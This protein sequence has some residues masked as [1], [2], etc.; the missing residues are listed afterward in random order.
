M[1]KLVLEKLNNSEMIQKFDETIDEIVVSNSVGDAKELYAALEGLFSRNPDFKTADPNIFNK[2]YE[3]FVAVRF[4][5]LPGM[6]SE[7]IVRLIKKNFS[8]VLNHPEY[9]LESKIRYKI[10]T[11][12]DLSERDAFKAKIKTVLLENGARLGRIKINV[13]GVEKDPTIANW[14]KDYYM[15]VGIE[16]ADAFKLNQHFTLSK[17]IKLLTPAEQIKLKNLFK[18]FELM[19]ISS[20]KFPQYDE[21]F[22]VILPN[23]EINLFSGGKLEKIPQEALK[24]FNE[25]TKIAENENK[26]EEIE[27][28]KKMLQNYPEGSLERRAIEEEMR[29]LESGIRNKE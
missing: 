18:F 8:F 6:E 11:I 10:K 9:D 3:Y 13:G 26:S 15:N 16:P 20:E 24:I 17:N 28:L 27:G 29:K 22:T 1:N 5:I 25:I 12:L 14:L 19:K 23:G 4:V 2:Y 21:D 7:T